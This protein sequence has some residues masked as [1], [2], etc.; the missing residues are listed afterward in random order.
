MFLCPRMFREAEYYLILS[1]AGC[2]AMSISIFVY[3]K[4]PFRGAFR[5]FHGLNISTAALAAL[6]MDSLSDSVRPPH[7]RHT[8]PQMMEK[9][10]AI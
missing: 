5:F 9:N 1:I 2:A 7:H 3:E 6:S 8:C 4:R 10:T